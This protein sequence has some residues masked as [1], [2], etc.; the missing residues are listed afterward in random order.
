MEGLSQIFVKI[1]NYY[2]CNISHFRERELT[3]HYAL[4]NLNMTRQRNK[5]WALV[6]FP[7]VAIVTLF[8]PV[9]LAQHGS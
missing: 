8:Q 5:A 9:N 3:A 6:L 7:V 4:L 2:Y 1:N